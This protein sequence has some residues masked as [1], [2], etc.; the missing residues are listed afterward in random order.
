MLLRFLLSGLLITFVFPL[1]SQDRRVVRSLYK[2]AESILLY[3]DEDEQALERFLMLEEMDPENANIQYKIGVCYLHIPGKKDQAIAPLE[4]AVDHISTTYESSYTERNAPR[5]AF[6]YLGMAYHYNNQ[7]NKAIE[8]Y[9]K[10]LEIADAADYYNIEFVKTQIQGCR[11]AL[12]YQKDPVNLQ[13]IMMGSSINRFEEN[14]NPAVSGNGRVIVFTS[15][16]GGRYRIMFSEKI[17][18]TWTVAKDITRELNARGEGISSS[19]SYD[20]Q[21]LFVYKDDKGL[22]NLY[23]SHYDGDRWESLERLNSHINTKYW[24]SACCLSPDGQTLYFTSNRRGGYGRLDIYRSKRTA[25]GDWGPA[26]NLGP[27]VNSPF[28]E[29]VPYLNSD[30]SLLF[31]SSQGHKSL[32]GFDHF[33]SKRLDSVSWSIPVNLGFPANTTDDDMFLAPL[34]SGD[35]VLYDRFVGGTNMKHAIHMM[36][37]RSDV[38]VA[39]VTLK[40]TMKLS[41]QD[42]LQDQQLKVRIIDA[43]T[44]KT[45]SSLIAD[46]VS[47]AYEIKLAPGQYQLVYEAEGFQSKEQTLSISREIPIGQINHETE[48]A[49]NE[50]IKGKYLLFENIYFDFNSYDLDKESESKLYRISSLMIENPGL[51]F[52]VIGHADTVGSKAYNIRLSNMRASNVAKFLFGTGIAQSRLVSKGVG[53]IRAIQV[54]RDSDKL[55]D[56]IQ[57]YNRRV[58]IRVLKSHPGQEIMQ[59]V[60]LPDL[61]RGKNDLDYTIIVLKV[62]E[63]LPP[64]YF[65]QYDIEELSYVREQEISDGYLYTL[66]GFAEKPPAVQMLGKLQSAGLTESRIVDQHEL[67][68]ELEQEDAFQGYLN[69]PGKI[70]EIPWYTIQIFALKKPPHPSAFRGRDDIQGYPCNDGFIRYCIGKYHGFSKALIDL[71]GIQEEWYKD[72]FI[73]E[74]DR[75]EKGLPPEPYI[76]E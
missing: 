61:A 15:L 36:I 63:R 38:E 35:T 73:Q 5:D 12:E 60:A 76:D 43:V 21:T 51:R 56:D 53:E 62:P 14:F 55:A 8:T 72:A 3:L 52:E 44:G 23:V 57:R 20:G 18:G 46:T 9:E 25:E 47:G 26:Q 30:G 6:F 19:L 75:M 59:E 67:S 22:G 17:N 34:G 70:D 33:Y 50:L 49:Q 58:E 24:E 32:G 40:G 65:D 74:L 11:L 41:G 4:Y 10:F 54:P 1:H 27:T 16:D 2:E 13:D 42:A 39:E 71:P 69:S 7:L 45:V 64:G 29:D 28:S 31:F 68:D 66:G 48:L 37:L